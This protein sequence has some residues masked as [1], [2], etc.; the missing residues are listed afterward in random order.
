M[1]SD[2]T[3]TRIPGQGLLQDRRTVYKRAITKDADFSFDPIRE[4]LQTFTQ[5]LVVIPAQGVSGYKA[6]VTVV[7][8]LI[9]IA[10]A[11]RPIV[12]SHTDDP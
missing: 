8:N 10:A 4:S 11:V 5:N 9:R 1:F 6:F 2:P 12:H 3:E 7:Q